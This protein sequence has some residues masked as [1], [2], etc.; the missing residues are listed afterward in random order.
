VNAIL[1][2]IVIVIPY[3]NTI[4]R[5][6]PA[7]SFVLFEPLKNIQ[8]PDWSNCAQHSGISP[9]MLSHSR[10]YSKCQF[11]KSVDCFC[12][13]KAISGCQSKRPD[14]ELSWLATSVHHRYALR[15]LHL[16][17]AIIGT[18]STSSERFY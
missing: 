7:F 17:S 11:C 5:S 18:V 1:L 3:Y 4:L 14:A 2:F 12:M 6:H 9:L 15:R 8:Y 16:W 13:R 10:G